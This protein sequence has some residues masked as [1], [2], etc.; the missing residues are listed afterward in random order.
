M[1]TVIPSRDSDFV[2]WA[3][4]HAPVFTAAAAAVGLTA[5]QA[6]AFAGA[7]TSVQQSFA[8]VEAARAALQGAQDAWAIAR[9]NSRRTAG[10]TIRFIKAFAENAKDPGA[11]Y[12]LASI[13]AP[14]APSPIGPPA[15]AT[16]LHAT[17]DV[18]TGTLTIRWKATQPKGMSGVVYQVQ[19][20][21]GSS[22]NFTQVGLTG[23]KNFEDF[24]IPSGASRVQYRV[25]A[26]R[27]SQQSQTS[28]VLDVRFG[29][30][31]QGETLIL[32]E[33]FAGKKLAA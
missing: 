12:A 26:Q 4:Q 21:I 32:S 8:T 14:N 9:L 23:S 19:R 3:Q 18:A 5:P 31:N 29:T 24:E 30:G 33:T 2:V 27:G 20:A 13:P 22:S 17:L 10:D 15:A 1:T 16:T 6:L 7:A 28:P 11:V 25:I